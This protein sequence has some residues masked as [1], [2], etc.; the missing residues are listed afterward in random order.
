M[1]QLA[2]FTFWIVWMNCS[3]SQDNL[4]FERK[5]GY[6]RFMKVKTPRAEFYWWDWHWR[7]DYFQREFKIYISI[8]THV[9]FYYFSNSHYRQTVLTHPSDLSWTKKIHKKPRN[10]TVPP[11]STCTAPSALLPGHGSTPWI[12]HKQQS[13]HPDCSKTSSFSHNPDKMKRQPC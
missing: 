10:I 1:P 4:R 5:G 13:L 9:C 6:C 11:L 3:N 12:R 7:A 2:F 8:H